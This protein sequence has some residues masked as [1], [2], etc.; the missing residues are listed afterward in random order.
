MYYILFTILN[1][2]FQCHFHVFRD[3]AQGF[4]FCQANQGEG[5]ER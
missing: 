2:D 5:R 4:G 1:F 3:G